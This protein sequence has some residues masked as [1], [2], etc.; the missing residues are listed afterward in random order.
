[1]SFSVL[2]LWFIPLGQTCPS[3]AE[4]VHHSQT[5]DFYTI[6]LLS[7]TLVNNT[8][9]FTHSPC[10]LYDKPWG[11]THSVQQHMLRAHTHSPLLQTP[12]STHLLP[13][14]P[15]CCRA[16]GRQTDG[17]DSSALEPAVTQH[18]R[19]DWQMQRWEGGRQV[20]SSNRIT[21]PVKAA[22]QA[23]SEQGSD[24]TPQG[25]QMTFSTT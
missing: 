22:G 6:Y 9:F 18:H 4:Q 3:G 8:S 14:G 5:H 7:Q 19:G 21:A 20:T 23:H 16:S 24:S 2:T 12:L 15:P 1:M 13:T 10:S 11:Q 25:L 17:S